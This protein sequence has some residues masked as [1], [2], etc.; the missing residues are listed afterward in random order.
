MD[1]QIDT[2]GSYVI[3]TVTGTLTSQHAE[4]FTERL[5]EFV[6]GDGAI[7]AI[8]LSQ[9]TMLDSTGLSAMIGLVTRSRLSNGRVA[10]IAPSPFVR[11]ILEVTH[12]DTWFEVFASREAASEAIVAD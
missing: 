5:Q 12:L 4:T 7:L 9:L 8:D 11:G 6:H 3:A 2:T 10:M 1:I